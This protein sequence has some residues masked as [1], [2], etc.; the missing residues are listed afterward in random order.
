MSDMSLGAPALKAD[1]SLLAHLLG[2]ALSLLDGDAAA[3]RRCIENACTLVQ[4]CDRPERSKNSLLAEWQ[5][6]RAKEFIR[7][8]LAASLRIETVAKLVNLSASY[9]SRAF[10][11][12]TGTSYSEFLAQS[13]IE[14][15]KRL[16]LTTETPISEIALACG[17]ADQSHL[18]RLFSKT[19]GLPPRAWRRNFAARPTDTGASHPAVRQESERIE[20][21]HATDRLAARS[22]AH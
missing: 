10:K 9:F 3:A 16:L 12:T 15:A 17:L 21:P 8:N 19:V 4:G 14:L 1:R 11:A 7:N 18:T 5:V 6:R 13:R 2:E 22:F 20:L